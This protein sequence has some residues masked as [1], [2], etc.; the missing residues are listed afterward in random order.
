MALQTNFIWVIGLSFA[1]LTVIFTESVLPIRASYLTRVAFDDATR[2]YLGAMRQFTSYSAQCV[3]GIVVTV[4]MLFLDDHPE[5][6]GAIAAG[7]C[8]TWYILSMPRILS[9]LREHPSRRTRTTNIDKSVC[10]LTFNELGAQFRRLTHYPEACKF[11]VAHMLAQFGGPVFISLTSTYG[12]SQLEI[13]SG[14]QMM[15]VAAIILTLGVP[16]T[17]ILAKLK[18]NDAI[19]FKTCWF[20][21]LSLNILIGGLVPFLANDG[22]TRSY[23]FLLLLA[24]LCGAVSIS[25][26]YC[27]GWPSFVV[28]IPQEEVA[29]YAGIFQF[30]NNIVQP[31]AFLIYLSI[32]QAT[33]SH[34]LAWG[35]TTTPFCVLSLIIMM[36]VRIDKGERTPAD[37]RRRMSTTAGP[38][39][40]EKGGNRVAPAPAVCSAS[41]TSA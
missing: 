4:V 8:G 26:F 14:L 36:R 34:P 35:C 1:A 25:W 16:L 28:L 7:L 21:V 27:I 41:P 40:D 30:C 17:L 38:G 6:W 39:V 10:A 19:S 18:K 3:F 5:V 24:G 37:E 12:P 32:V 20:V 15:L 2:G 31:F 9:M 11:L 22:T 23:L 29:A 13:T 33:N